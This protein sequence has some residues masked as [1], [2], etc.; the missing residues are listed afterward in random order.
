[1]ITTPAFNDKPKNYRQTK[2][3]PTIQR[4]TDK[5]NDYRLLWQKEG[6]CDTP[7][8]YLD[9]PLLA[10][11]SVY[12]R[13][14]LTKIRVRRV[15]RTDS[16]NPCRFILKQA[17]ELALEGNREL[18]I[19]LVDMEKAYDRVPREEVYWCLR[20]R[21]VSEKLVRVIKALYQDSRT[22]VQCGAGATVTF[23]GK[24]ALHQGSVLSPFLF[25]LVVDTISLGA[26]RLL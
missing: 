10:M 2:E 18:Y 3:L 7:H 5:P 9:T 24:V 23:S 15:P 1:M 25:A 6:E 11:F 19:A 22:T 8:P 12:I 14:C 4:I 17:Q 16:C 20:K 13:Q 21:S 26:R